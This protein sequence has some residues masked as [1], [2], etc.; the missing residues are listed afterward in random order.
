MSSIISY[1]NGLIYA[2][3]IA[4]VADGELKDNELLM[5]S[6]IVKTLPVFQGFDM[7]RLSRV[8]GDCA[9]M[10]DQEDGI[11]AALGLIKEAL[12]S[13]LHETAYALACDVVAVDGN[14]AQEELRWLDMLAEGLH[15][16]Q[17]HV[18]AI[19]HAARA[20]YMR[21]HDGSE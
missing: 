1:Q 21:Y 8:T 4:A 16:S 20:R 13:K 17:L 10:L 18:I 19:K 14:A 6:E 3:V 2:M 12:P 9:A 7:A 5:I 15:I 11:D